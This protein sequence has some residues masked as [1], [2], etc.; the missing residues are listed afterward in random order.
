MKIIS[1]NVQGLGKSR[2]FRE[3][4]K[5]LQELRPQILFLSETKMMAKQMEAK[6]RMLKFENCFVVDRCGLGGGL[7]LLWTL[8][9]SLEVKSYSKHHIDAVIHNENG[10][11]W[12]C[13]G[14]YGHPKSEKKKHTW[15][16]LRR[17]AGM[18]SLPWLCFG[19]FNEIFN[20]N[21]KVGGKERNP[22][23][24]HEFRQAV[25]DCRLLDLG[26]KGYPFTWSNRR[27][28]PQLIEERLD[29]FFCN[30]NWGS[31]YQETAAKNLISWSSDHSP[32]LM[33]LIGK[34]TGQRYKRR[35]FR[36]V[37]YEDM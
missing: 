27:F 29:R 12:R 4:Q 19:D 32:I 3:A 30:Q 21:E 34:E 18:S 11:S 25:R 24:V 7:A 31:L 5:L 13:I 10:S 15:S 23:R 2:T 6:R 17:L 8:D 37:H 33:E 14:V 26:L 28:G 36:R 16:L 1:W 20:L 22:S 35:T 9:V